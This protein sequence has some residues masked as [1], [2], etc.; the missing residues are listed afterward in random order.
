M[1]GSD[2]I[3]AAMRLLGALPSGQSPSTEEMADG[4]FTL[5]NLLDAWS[6]DELSL[7]ATRT[8]SFPMLAGTAT[9]AVPGARPAKILSAD[10]IV[11]GVIQ[12]ALEVVGPERWAQIPNKVSQDPQPSF[13][14]CD[15]AFP[16]PNVSLAQTPSL[17]GTVNL[18]V[19]VD[20]AAIAAS[21]STFAMPQGYTRAVTYN[22]AVELYPEFPRAGGLDPMVVKIAADSLADLKKTA[23]S[24]K[25]G[26]STLTLPPVPGS[27]NQGPQ[28]Q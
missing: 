8:Q 26:K 1:L 22:L 16:T 23:A 10:V 18:Y 11:A 7:F 2:I 27:G 9:Y 12:S 5:Q 6:D 19:T 4:L 13:I 17:A 25:A 15:Y 24:N 14:Y 3:T 28:Q 21:G 20:L